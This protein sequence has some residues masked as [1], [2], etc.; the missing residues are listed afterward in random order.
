MRPSAELLDQPLIQE[1]EPDLVGLFRYRDFSGG[2]VA[3]ITESP[4]CA[5]DENLSLAEETV[6]RMLPRHKQP[7]DIRMDQS[8]W[9]QWQ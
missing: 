6:F 9:Y 2:P 8:P 1:N 3:F 7:F 5:I 4:T